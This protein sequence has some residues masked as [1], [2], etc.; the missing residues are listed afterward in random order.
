MKGIEDFVVKDGEE[1]ENISE[2][3][4]DKVIVVIKEKYIGDTDVINFANGEI[5]IPTNYITVP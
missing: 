3:N 4:A 5:T 1:I 2:V